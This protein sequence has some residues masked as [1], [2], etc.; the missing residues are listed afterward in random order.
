MLHARSSRRRERGF[1]F[2]EV[3]SVIA[4]LGI[5]AAIAMPSFIQQVYKGRRSDALTEIHR[6]SQAQERV[7]ATSPTYS[8]NVG[9]GTGNLALTAT[10]V[11]P[12]TSGS[13]TSSQY[14]SAGGLYQITVSTD[15]TVA[16]GVAAN[17]VGYT[18]TATAIN[19]SLGDSN[20]RTLTMAMTAQGTIGYTS[21]TAANAANT[22]YANDRCWNR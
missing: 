13:I 5:L 20:C 2:I 17:S 11:T 19:G 16:S 21:T 14:N 9:A 8:A 12:T 6:A 3:L 4:I 7:R 22:G 15:S 10:A 1:T 18:I